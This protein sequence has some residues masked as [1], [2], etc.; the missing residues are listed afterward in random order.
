[1]KNAV[2]IIGS[3][4]IAALLLTIPIIFG[5]FIVLK[6]IIPCLFFGAG[7]IYELMLLSL[8]IYDKATKD[9]EKK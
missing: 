6:N 5:V 7:I 9:E 8:Y 2:N 3:V 1:M 4:I